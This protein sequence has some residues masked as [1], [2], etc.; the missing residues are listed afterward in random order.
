MPYS[1]SWGIDNRL[2]SVRDVTLGEDASQARAGAA[3]QVLSLLWDL[4]SGMPRNAG[5]TNLSAARR[6][7]AWQ[8]GAVLR[9]LGLARP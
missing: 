6:V 3:P 8:P 5:R 2:H 4:V 9:L 7:N 1:G